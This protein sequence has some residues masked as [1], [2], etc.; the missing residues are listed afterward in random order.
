MKRIERHKLKENEFAQYCRAGAR[1]RWPSGSARSRPRSSRSSRSCDRRRGYSRGARRATPRRRP[2]WRPRSRWRRRRSSRR[3]RRRPGARRRCQQPGTYRTEQRAPRSGAA[4]AERGRRQISRTPSRASRRGSGWPRRWRSSAATRGGAAIPGS[5]Q[6]AG[7]TQHLPA[8]GAAGSANAQ[9]A[10][11]KADAA[12]TTFR[13][14][15]RPTAIRSCR[16]T[17][18]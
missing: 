6:K 12:I 3:H 11:G 16:W 13:G 15:S 7:P 9:L 14:R 5:G 4:A 17:A 18:C 8:D 1:G 2:C 10:Q